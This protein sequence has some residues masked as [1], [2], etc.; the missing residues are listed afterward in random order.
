MGDPPGTLRKSHPD[1]VMNSL[2]NAGSRHSS[3][4]SR[5]IFL[6]ENSL[7]KGK[8]ILYTVIN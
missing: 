6:N 5:I 2:M 1:L 3:D 4:N 7:L 8:K